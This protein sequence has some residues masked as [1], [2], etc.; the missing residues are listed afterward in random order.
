[1]ATQV[2]QKGMKLNGKHQLF[3][4]AGDINLLCEDVLTVR[5][6]TNFK[7]GG[8]CRSKFLDRCTRMF[9]FCEQNVGQYHNMK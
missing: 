6:N 8:S 1:M 3:V 2:N 7:S 5:K 9:M 4:Y